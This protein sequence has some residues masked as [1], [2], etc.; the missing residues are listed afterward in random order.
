MYWNPMAERT[1]GWKAEEVLGK[2]YSAVPDDQWQ[3]HRGFIE[4]TLEME[5]GFI[6][7][8]QRRRKDGSLI[9]VTIWAAPLRSPGGEAEA[10]VGVF[11][12]VTEQKKLERQLRQAQKM[13]AVGRLASGIAHDFNNL[14]TAIGG[15][16]DLLFDRCE[17]VE[18]R[19]DLEEIRN[20]VQRATALTHRILGF[21][22]SQVL[23]IE[24]LDLNR[25][26]ERARALVDRLIGDDIEVLMELDVTS[27]TVR[28][29]AGQLDQVILN[30]AVNARDAMPEG[31]TVT[32][33]T[34]QVEIDEDS[35]V[36]VEAGPYGF[37]RVSDTGCGMN[38]VTMGQIFDPF[39]TTKKEGEGTGLGLSTVCAMVERC[40]G[41]VMVE[42]E[43]Q[44]GATFDVY[45]PI[46]DESAAEG[47]GRVET[48]E[49]E[50]TGTETILV[51]EDQ[52][53]V[54]SVI[55]RSLMKYGYEVL[56]AATGG[57]ALGMI[58]SGG[59]F[60][61][62]VTDLA[63]PELGGAELAE[64][65]LEL[66]RPRTKILLISGHSAGQAHHGATSSLPFL[67]K[68]FSPADLVR[69]VRETLDL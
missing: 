28:A 63:M 29:D 46:T 30:L 19:Q 11:V 33:T 69:K 38:E 51:V 6:P 58:K 39:F 3:A 59:Q 61:L 10:V 44:N 14:L 21:G 67:A 45:L 22:R 32:I 25:A 18:D 55:R 2:P 62:L 41:A 5:G 40:G 13:E 12:D 9:D 26:V 56:E 52:Q 16:A 17:S 50:L 43:P 49:I 57:E 36:P 47:G 66:Q 60:D 27:P 37:L 64:R 1:L 23:S 7:E 48:E 15:H 54:R 42:S 68:P 4:R 24:P 31:G 35:G 8:T 34:G 53:A 20:S 65:L